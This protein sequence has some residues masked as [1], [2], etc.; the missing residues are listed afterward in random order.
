MAAIRLPGGLNVRKRLLVYAAG[1]GCFVVFI[2]VLGGSVPG[3]FLVPTMPDPSPLF[4]WLACGIAVDAGQLFGA[5][6]PVARWPKASVATVIAAVAITAG[7]FWR[8]IASEYHLVFGIALLERDE[9]SAEEHLA[10]AYALRPDGESTAI[11]YSLSLSFRAQDHLD[12]QE[13]KQAIEATQDAIEVF[14]DSPNNYLDLGMVYRQKGEPKLYVR[15]CRQAVRV[16]NERTP[17]DY[18]RWLGG[19]FWFI[20]SPSECEHSLMYA[21]AHEGIPESIAELIAYIEHDE[22]EFVAHAATVLAERGIIEAVKQLQHRLDSLD[23]NDT[24]LR[25]NLREAID[26]L[27]A[28]TPDE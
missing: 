12:R 25:E 15:Y 26:Q 17:E 8:P 27:T 6:R 18:E 9:A 3:G 21:L 19:S 22:D 24:Q 16:A 1:L 2:L 11:I 28:N 13:Y 4:I 23:E 5:S 10:R 7:V 14:P 20:S